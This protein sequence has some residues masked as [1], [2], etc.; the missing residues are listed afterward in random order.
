MQ[1]PKERLLSTQAQWLLSIDRSLLLVTQ[2][3]GA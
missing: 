1:C 3:F 2:P